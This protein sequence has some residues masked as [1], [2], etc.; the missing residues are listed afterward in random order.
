MK[1]K[2][3]TDIVQGHELKYGRCVAKSRSSTCNNQKVVDTEG[4]CWLL[5]SHDTATLP[6]NE[7]V[8]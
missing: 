4:L 1:N 5:C 3:L 2:L 6:Q 8:T 7:G